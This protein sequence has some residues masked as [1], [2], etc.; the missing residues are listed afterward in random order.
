MKPLTTIRQDIIASIVVFF[1]ALPLCLGIAFASGA[2]LISG[3]LSGII[4]GLVVGSISGSH[5]SV[6]G[7]AAGLTAI[8]LA[9]IT[10]LGGFETFLLAVVLAGIIQIVL[11]VIK[12]GALSAFFPSSVI[13]GLLAAIGVILILKQIP[14]LLGHDKVPEGD[15]AFAGKGH[16]N[17]FTELFSVFSGTFH[18]GAIAVGLTSLAFLIIWDKIPRLKKSLVPSSVIVVIL[19]LAMSEILSRFSGTWAIGPDHLVQVPIA[20]DAQSLMAWFA[21]P[22]WSKITMSGVYLAAFTIAIVASLETLLNLEAVDKL[23]PLQR[24]SPPNR[25]LIAQGI[26]N[27][28]CGLIG[29]IPLT[30]V[31][32]RSS[33]NLNAGARTKLSA[34]L[35][36]GLLLVSVLAFP[37]LLNKIPLACLAAILIVTGA[38]LA[39]WKLFKQMVKEGRYQAIP[40]FVTLAAIVLTDLLIGIL[41]GLAISVAFILF[42]NLRSPVR[43]V[44]EKQIEADVLHI[45]LASQVSFLNRA[46]LENTLFNAAPGTHVLING[47]STQYIDPDIISLIRDFRDNTAPV[48]DLTVSTMGFDPKFGLENQINYPQVTTKELQSRVTPEEV[49]QALK[50][51]NERFRTGNRITRDLGVQVSGTSGGQFPLAMVLTCIDSRT[52][53]E[54]IFD[55]GIGDT[56][57]ARVAGNIAHDKIIGSMEYACAVAG[58]KLIVVLG[59]TQC[60]A[61]NSSVRLAIDNKTAVEATGCGNLDTLVDEIQKSIDHEKC[62]CF[63]VMGDDAKSEFLEDVTR[64][65]VR[66]SMKV[67]IKNSD[68]LRELIASGKVMLIGAIYDVCTGR[69]E[70]FDEHN[71]TN[72]TNSAPSAAVTHS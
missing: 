15:M 22:D 57:T 63:D 33:V 37:V 24:R 46:A 50:I 55:L 7:P 38:K 20:S 66:N 64:K 21:F 13:K 48:H 5:S 10:S 45:Q 31:V 4:G 14:H 17:T 26:G 47:S 41:I 28:T 56:F 43:N 39:N 51:G 53:T 71:D 32:V 40:F 8:V 25:E 44:L 70:F 65:N 62:R 9:Q 49:L 58:A 59:H 6:S 34:I 12:A 1:V 16:G 72:T 18:A 30:S 2:P 11:G 19:G 68:K 61:V 23:D 60:G 27:I 3:I 29:A 54:I 36:G 35:H 42:S 52:P 67:I 69:V